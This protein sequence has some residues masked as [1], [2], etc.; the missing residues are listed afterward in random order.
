MA[1]PDRD[2]PFRI[3]SRVLPGMTKLIEE[4]GEVTQVIGKI[5]GL[6]SMGLHWDGTVLRDELADELGDLI[7]AIGFMTARNPEIDWDRIN[8]RAKRKQARFD[9]WHRNILAGRKPGDGV[10]Y[11]KDEHAPL[12]L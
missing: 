2:I 1:L 8:I 6:G 9:Q 3:G 12:D 10:V 4:M 11:D 7:G 5:M